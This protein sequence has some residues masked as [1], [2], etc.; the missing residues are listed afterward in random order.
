M[1]IIP[2]IDLLDGKVV[3]LTKGN[4][5][6]S[7]IYSK[8]P[9]GIAK[10]W[11]DEGAKLLHLV[12]LSAAFG[13]GDNLEITKNIIR[14][15]KIK[16]EVGGGVREIR[17]AKALLEAG[18]ERIIIGTKSIEKDFLENIL[19]S[20][21]SQAIA[22]SVDVDNGFVAVKGWQE[23]TRIRSFEFIQALKEQ[24]IRWIVYTDICRDGTL[25][26]P[27]YREIKK[28]SSFKDV[29]FIVSGGVASL[30]DVKNIIK[31]TPF[32]WGIIIGKALYEGKISLIEI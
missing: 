10:K 25:R 16:V 5:K 26:G 2:A 19:A 17:K 32:V 13:E 3:R 1:L 20:C 24:G 23:K 18:A 11:E 30:R 21:G 27:N 9:I 28:L 22:V 31:E 8:D 6:M 12:D 15:V 29:N 14:A 7:K 4:P